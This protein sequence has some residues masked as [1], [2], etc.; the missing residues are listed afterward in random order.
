[1]RRRN[2]VIRAVT[3]IVAAALLWA[4]MGIF[5]RRLALYNLDTMAVVAVRVTITAVLLV[6]VTLV[7]QP[8]ALRVRLRDL[9]CFAGTGIASIV[10]FNYCYFLTITLTSLSVAAVL[11]YTA[12]AIVMVLSLVLFG[13]RPTRRKLIA[14]GLAFAGCVLAT[15]ASTGTAAQLNLRGVLTGLGAGLGYALYSI[16]GRYAIHRGYSPL[17]ITAYTFIFASLGVAVLAD[18][19]PI[20]HAVVSEP[21][22]LAW[23]VA[24]AICTTVAPYLLYTGGLQHVESSRAAIL[25]SVEPVG[26]TMI[27]AIVFGEHLSAQGLAGV[28]M[29]IASVAMLGS[30]AGRGT[31][32]WTDRGTREPV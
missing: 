32:N 25:A 4:T 26:A 12:P 11:L 1:M 20:V 3:S 23:S 7:R 18:L 27:G 28:A 6:G 8:A 21:P 10:F 9:W 22:L 2:E 15:G 5:V 13:E 14:L 24:M 16:F 19:G 31:S 29:V 17:T 30:D